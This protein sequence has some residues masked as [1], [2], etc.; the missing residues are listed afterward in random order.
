MFKDPGAYCPGTMVS[1]LTSAEMSAPG[2]PASGL[3]FPAM[4]RRGGGCSPSR[5]SQCGGG[6]NDNGPHELSF[7]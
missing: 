4:E 3:V 1:D 6:Q 7:R 5:S 2:R